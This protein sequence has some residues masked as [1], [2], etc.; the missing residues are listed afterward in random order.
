VYGRAVNQC[1][2]QNLAAAIFALEP[3]VDDGH[4]I[5]DF[6]T[7]NA[8]PGHNGL[9]YRIVEHF[10]EVGLAI[11]IFDPFGAHEHLL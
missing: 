9:D 1:L 4:Q 2:P 3:G 7:L 10:V 8:V 11:E 6:P 5:F